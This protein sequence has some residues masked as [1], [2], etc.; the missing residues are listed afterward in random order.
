MTTA[1]AVDPIDLDLEPD[2]RLIRDE[3]ERLLADQ[4][5]AARLRALLTTQGEFDRALWGQLTDLGWLAA[6]LPVEEGGLALGLRTRCRMAEALGRHLAA[7][8]FIVTTSALAALA[9]LGAPAPLGDWA[10]AGAVV[11]LACFEA[12][13]ADIPTGPRTEWR[14]GRLYGRK[15]SVAA[16]R[17][18][19]HAL[20]QARDADGQVV[21]VLAD[22]AAAG[23][24]RL[25]GETLDNSRGYA[26]VEFDGVAAARVGGGEVLDGL[27][28]QVA[29]ATA[30][31][32]VGG[33][34][35]CL[36]AARDHALQR[37]AF[38]KV[39][40]A[41]QAVKHLLADMYVQIE[42]AKGAAGAALRLPASDLAAAAAGARLAA[43][44]AYDFCAQEAIQLHGAMGAT[45][46]SPLH[47]HYRR[48]RCLALEWGGPPMWRRR[49]LGAVMRELAA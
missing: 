14:E 6:A 13:D 12:P 8:P 18:A 16:G 20:V 25:G 23:V 44:Q 38:G 32:Q 7:T 43:S 35:A 24:V 36:E 37:W 26:A 48:A 45:W 9:A 46:D 30:F 15:T 22:L 10:S 17:F 21:I 42:L 41:N 2:D 4:D 5:G 3:F 1:P 29:L 34:Q 47:L 40:G 33:A 11:T 49:M 39:I 28:D 27:L 31:E 19:D